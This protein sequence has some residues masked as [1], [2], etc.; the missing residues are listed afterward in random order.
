MSIPKLNKI[1]YKPKE[2]LKTG[3]SGS[4]MVGIQGIVF[5]SETTIPVTNSTTTTAKIHLPANALILDIGM[6]TTTKIDAATSSDV[7]LSFGTSSGG[8][9]ITAAAQIN[10]TNDD[11]A[12]GT[13]ISS[14]QNNLA[15]TSGNAVG[16][17]KQGATLFSTSNRYIYGNI[18]ISGA[19]LSAAGAVR[20]FIKYTLV[21]DTF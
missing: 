3:I 5:S 8:A 11:I 1:T 21:E 6:V 14:C 4:G 19:E 12:A 13:S 17:F 7:T 10:N 15:H 16:V 2:G 18:A 9:E 20:F